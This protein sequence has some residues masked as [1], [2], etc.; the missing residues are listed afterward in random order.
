VKKLILLVIPLGAALLVTAAA[1]SST[2][3]ST[4]GTTAAAGGSSSTAASS[5]GGATM[6]TT[7]AG[8]S[9][10]SAGSTPSGNIPVYGKTD[11]NITTAVG[12][13]FAIELE[14]NP[15]TGF[16]WTYSQVGGALE[17][18]DQTK[19]TSSGP[20]G[21]GGTQRFT[22]KAKV[23]GASYLDFV[24]ARSNPG[25]DDTKLRYDVSID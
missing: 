13:E 10:G 11:L 22:F 25:P 20:P 24:Y 12:Q 17:L 16:S 8:S 5:T 7:T 18:V 19:A 4:T 23:S 1:C 14:S 3:T 9:P 6:P 15:S 2:S 21:S